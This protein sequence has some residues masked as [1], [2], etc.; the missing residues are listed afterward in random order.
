MTDDQCAARDLAAL[1]RWV[2]RLREFAEQC[3]ASTVDLREREAFP[4]EWDNAMDLLDDVE[5]LAMQGQLP[6]E[7]LRDLRDVACDLLHLAPVIEHLRLRVPDQ[8]VLARAA[9][10]QIASRTV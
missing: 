7:A 6:P 9:S 1:H 2:L 3:E 5:A 4:L 10:R 8:G